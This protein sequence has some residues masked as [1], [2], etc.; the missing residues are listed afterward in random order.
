MIRAALDGSLAAVETVTDPIFGLAIPTSCPGV[1]SEVLVPRNTWRDPEAYD[2][3]A[4]KLKAMFEEN[5]R[6]FA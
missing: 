5:F 6:K 4:N 1:P 2:A 3:Q